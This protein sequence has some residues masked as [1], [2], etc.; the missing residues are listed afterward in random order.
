MKK[1]L[2]KHIEHN[3]IVDVIVFM[4][5]ADSNSSTSKFLSA[6]RCPPSRNNENISSKEN[7]A[8]TL[9]KYS[10]HQTCIKSIDLGMKKTKE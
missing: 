2:S 1:E 6:Q 8:P 5:W 9:T 7:K 10:S 4:N 3:T